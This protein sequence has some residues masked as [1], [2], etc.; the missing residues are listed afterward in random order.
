MPEAGGKRIWELLRRDETVIARE[1]ARLFIQQV[2]SGSEG[3]RGGPPVPGGSSSASTASVPAVGSADE[4]EA[5]VA[6][7]F[8]RLTSVVA[9]SL[10]VEEPRLVSEELQWLERSVGAHFA[11][12]PRADYL[13]LLQGSFSAACRTSLSDEHCRALEELLAQARS[14]LA[15][16]EPL[17]GEPRTRSN[18]EGNPPQDN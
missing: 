15:D 14:G 12:A 16:V 17:L 7:S 10:Q 11:N 4:A 13:G 1:A 5:I 3:W 2:R 8:Q 9:L 18:L 6:D